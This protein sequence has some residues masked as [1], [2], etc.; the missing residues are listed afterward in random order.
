VSAQ[1]FHDVE[2][3]REMLAR[4][5]RMGATIGLVPT[6]GALHEGH[7]RL[8]DAA[9][10]ETDCV[11][12]S[13]FVNPIQFDRPD[14]F[15]HYPRTLD[16]DH[17]FCSDRGADLIFA[18]SAAE[19]YPAPQRTFV[20]VTR[21]SERLC[22]ESRPGHFRGV[23]TVVL[24]LF[25][26][27]QPDR[28]FFGEK[29]AQQLAVIRRMVRDLN[30]P[31]EIAPV[32]TVRDSDGLA[33]SS[34]NKH[35]N[36]DERRLAPIL[37]QAL[38]VAQGLIATGTTDPAI[39]KAAASVVLAQQPAA[40]VEYLEVVDPE[41]MQP[42]ENIAGPVRVAA[43]IWLGSTRLIDNMLCEPGPTEGT[44]LIQ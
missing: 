22:G 15:D 17:Q 9:R 14:D 5:R 1:L 13:I 34:R 18:P 25:N 44:T 43:A 4:V 35:L 20:D 41:E 23:A 39:V 12:V 3:M 8:I 16:A 7:G 31:V 36:A 32:P 26:I 30:L 38:L 11:V 29:D 6:M 19:M 21:V 37:F 27:L 42:V 10:R 40:R 33:L 2:E 24:K 28:A